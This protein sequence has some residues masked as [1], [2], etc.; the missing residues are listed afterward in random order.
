ML[1]YT[2]MN[3]LVFASVMSRERGR[4]EGRDLVKNMGVVFCWS[5]FLLSWCRSCIVKG[6]TRVGV[7]LS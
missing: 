3:V 4:G 1:G 7:M 6:V 5:I 2:V